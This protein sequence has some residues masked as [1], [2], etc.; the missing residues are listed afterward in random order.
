M[1]P[2]DELTES[3][4]AHYLA[5]E[6]QLIRE[7][8][9]LITPDPA[10]KEAVSARSIG[11]INK[12]R[13]HPD[14]NRG[15][16]AFM[17]EY[18]LDS[19]EGIRLMTL[20]EALAR[21]PDE[22]TKEALIRS[23]LTGA[24]W[25][26]HI[27]KSLSPLVNSST[28]A[29]LFTSTVLES[30]EIP[31]LSSVIRNLGEPTIRM[32]LEMG[33][34]MFSDHFVLGETLTEA[35]K[36][37]ARER[38]KYRY[39][40]D[41][42]GEAALT[43]NDASKFFDAYRKAIEFA[44]EFPNAAVSIKLSALH[45]R[46]DAH[47]QTRVHAELYPP[48][49]E[50]VRIAREL[51]VQI[52]IDA[53]E[54]NRL[55]LSLQI[56]EKL[57]NEGHGHGF[58]KIGLAV[59][60]Y[61]RRAYSVLEYL[62]ALAA[63][64]NQRICVRLV[65]GAYWDTEVKLAQMM[66]LDN[67]PVFTKKAHTDISYLAC[68]KFLIN[69][70]NRLYP[71][72]ATHNVQTVAN[73]LYW[74][75]G[76]ESMFEFQRLHGM[77]SVLY[78]CLLDEDPDIGC[79]IYAPIGHQKELLPYL[80]RR[81][82]ENSA[83]SSFVNQLASE[84]SAEQLSMHPI[85]AAAAVRTEILP[86]PEL[87]ADRENSRGLDP[88]YSRHRQAL[89]N[90]LSP[91]RGRCW[92]DA[93]TQVISSPVDGHICGRVEVA[94]ADHINR[95]VA[96]AQL[97]ADNWG[98]QSQA[99]RSQLIRNLAD[100]LQA[101]RTRLVAMLIDEAGKTIEDAI[102]E[103]RE[104]IDFCRYYANE[105]ETLMAPLQLPGPS[106]ESNR[107]FSEPR[108]VMAAISPWNFPV[109]IFTGQLVAGLVTGNAVVA[110]PAEQ[111]PLVAQFIVSL[112]VKAGIPADTLQLL[113]GDGDTGAALVQHPGIDGVVF[114]GSAEVAGMINRSLAARPGPIVPMIAETGGQ[115]VMVVDSSALPEQVVKDVLTSAFNSCG[116]R[117]SA[118]RVLY[119]QE[120]CADTVL[121]LLSGAMAELRVG[122]PA[123]LETD[124]GPLIDACALS[125]LRQHT[126]EL[127]KTARL[128]ARS[129]LHADLP[130]GHYFAPC[131]YEIGSITE[132]NEEFFGPILHVVRYAIADID[133][134]IAD[135]NATGFG[136]TFG[137]HSRNERFVD[138]LVAT[139]QAGNIYVN[140]NIVGA[141]VGTQPFGG[142]GLSGTGPKA[143]GPRYLHRFVTEKTRT[144][145]LAAIGGAIDLINQ[146]S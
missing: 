146:H 78:D 91:L 74:T 63:Q 4:A 145:N 139:I 127:D 13:A 103:V 32:A 130:P 128:V 143:G 144:D 135:I 44:G 137:V 107:L 54:A 98:R 104:A 129:P 92:S 42:L 36:K 24:D 88:R 69:E 43:R 87:Y 97:A 27:G 93:G 51:D 134:V 140:R 5:D 111:T 142:R 117:C 33:M 41:M 40:F 114:T 59:Q 76:H 19:S 121:E 34:G 26:R 30:N 67:Y 138:R 38:R 99:V 22:D 31:F 126:E 116:Q 123:L 79:T 68:A 82:L 86:P 3:I 12:I 124:I 95:S 53:E 112:A 94:S 109:A 90:E 83:N 85:D 56:F 7:Y 110:K 35:K 120:S 141:V 14:F 46:Y 108:G 15:L 131:C 70:R 105:G 106:G 50:L 132:L 81:L 55:E 136:L 52:T 10:E 62:A 73:L 100:L 2:L 66:G 37:I 84:A 58:N 57:V 119:L 115:N 49:N 102:A 48:L 39:S 61:S 118:L 21:I 18:G 9:A 65:K 75:E 122:N 28:R 23:K 77:G 29:L 60:A 71:Q 17:A 8:V 25:S 11:L 20:A 72:F 64:N 125:R 6:K 16:D 113:V 101:E 47:Q 133:Q 45:P 89:L 96:A 1:R 80:I